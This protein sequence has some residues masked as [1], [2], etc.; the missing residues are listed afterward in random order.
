MVLMVRLSALVC[1][2]AATAAAQDDPL[3]PLLRPDDARYHLVPHNPATFGMLGPRAQLAARGFD[4]GLY[5]PPPQV[6]GA[7]E[8][9]GN[10]R[11]FMSPGFRFGARLS[12]KQRA[13]RR[14]LRRV[15]PE[16]LVLGLHG[17]ERWTPRAFAARY[18]KVIAKPRCCCSIAGRMSINPRRAI[19]PHLC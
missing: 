1:L 10:I 12:Q 9:A 16:Q 4:V 14:I 8:Q 3:A 11:H 6:E 19:T 13:V 2:L 5:R 15:P 17:I 18:G 7:I